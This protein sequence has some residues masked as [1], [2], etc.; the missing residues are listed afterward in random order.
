MAATLKVPTVFTAKDNFTPHLN[1]MIKGVGRFNKSLFYLNS[2]VNKTFSNIGKGLG[3]FGLF[4]GATAIYGAISSFTGV[5]A[6]FEQANANLSSVMADATARDMKLLS[7]QAINLGGSTAKTATEIVGLQEVLARKGLGANQILPM[8]KGIIDASVAMNSELA[9]TASLITGIT[10]V[11]DDLSEKD[12]VKISNQLV[13]ANQVSD[14]DFEKTLEALPIF[15]KKAGLAGDDLA[16]SLSYLGVLFDAQQRPSIAGTALRKM[17]SRA[18][19]AGVPLVRMLENVN[20]QS[21]NLS[22]SRKAFELFGE[23]AATQAVIIAT[24]LGEVNRIN[25][26][27]VNSNNA[28]RIAAKKQLDTIKGR[29]TLLKSAYEG[30]VLSIDKGNGAFSRFLKTILEVSTELLGLWKNGKF[31][32]E[33]Y[34][35]QEMSIV[36]YAKKANVFIKTLLYVGATL[37]L[38]KGYLLGVSAVQM[39]LSASTYIAIASMYAWDAV[40][41][42]STVTMGLFGIA[43]NTALWPITL[44]IISLGALIALFVYWDN[45]VTF[46]T[47]SLD[48]ITR[49]FD[50]FGSV[51]L[52]INPVIY[53]T[54]SLFRSLG[55]YWDILS[56]SFSENNI[57]DFFKDIG[58]VIVDFLIQPIEHFLKLLSYMPDWLGGGINSD[59]ADLLKASRNNLFSQNNGVDTRPINQ[60]LGSKESRVTESIENVFSKGFLNIGINNNTNFDIETEQKGGIPIML[61]TTMQ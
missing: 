44:L 15:A 26:E 40:F 47:K 30:L 48:K 16:S 17:Y 2:R 61:Q 36:S 42:V 59:A 34:T 57:L 39:V 20:N 11:Y 19:K 6:D 12:S 35:E 22:K 58:L 24:S 52:F 5:I 4:L 25:K 51:L 49:I 31:V 37:L 60:R 41:A 27:V 32:T 9:E 28:A 54:I 53:L 8:T 23:T 3:R 18:A 46:T 29:V 10:K 45:V 50:K 7:D 38:I 13:R 14:L 55:K 1:K 21:N 56:N 43:V 33:G